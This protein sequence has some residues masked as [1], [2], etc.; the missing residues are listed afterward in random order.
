MQFGF[1]VSY[2][3]HKMIKSNNRRDGGC[4]SGGRCNKGFGNPGS[5]YGKTGRTPEPD[6]M[7]G[8]HDTPHCPEQTDKRGCIPGRGQ[9][10]NHS[11]H[12]G[13]LGVNG[14]AQGPFNIADSGEFGTQRRPV[15]S[16]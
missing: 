16:W 3:L 9:K 1:D 8:I 11:G 13:G 14:P 12:A 5:D 7:E 15:G 10:R 6:T 2:F 4:Q